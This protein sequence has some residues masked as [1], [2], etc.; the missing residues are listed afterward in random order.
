MPKLLSSK[1]ITKVLEKNNFTLVSQ[2]GSH[3]KWRKHGKEILTVIVP[4]NKREIPIGTMRS[5]IRQSGLSEE[6]FDI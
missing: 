6:D 1:E 5:I 3:M 4:A 2:K